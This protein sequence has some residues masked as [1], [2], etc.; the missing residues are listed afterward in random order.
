MRPDLTAP[1][2]PT[3]PRIPPGMLK[4]DFL[5]WKRFQ[6]K[7]S[8]M[9]KTVYFNVRIG[10]PAPVIENLPIE[11]RK[12]AED[13]SR[14]RIDIVGETV[15][16]WWIIELK[17]SAGASALGQAILYRTLWRLE[18]PDQRPVVAAIVTDQTDVNIAIGARENG[19]VL[20]VI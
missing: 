13:L 16:N 17:P 1:F 18:P 14:R 7:F 4:P 3:F 8:S 2:S 9:F 6:A 11:I 5:I 20:I 15:D 12:L 10:E 19:I